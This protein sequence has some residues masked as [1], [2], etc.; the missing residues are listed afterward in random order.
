MMCGSFNSVNLTPLRV[1]TF[2]YKVLGIQYNKVSKLF[3]R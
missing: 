1:V 3:R 2:N